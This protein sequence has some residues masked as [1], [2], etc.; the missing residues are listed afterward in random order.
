MPIRSFNLSSSKPPFA[1]WYVNIDISKWLDEE[2]IDS[3]SYSAKRMDTGVDVTSDI[4]DSQKS[5]WN[6]SILRVWIKGGTDKITYKVIASV[7]TENSA[8]DQW[9][10]IFKVEEL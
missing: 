8:K 6:E 1:Q 9:A 4:I 3:V 7:T 10:L 5:G 2:V